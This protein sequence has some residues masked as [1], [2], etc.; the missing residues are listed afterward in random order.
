MEQEKYEKNA[1][2]IIHLVEGMTYT[3]WRRIAHLIG[4]NFDRAQNVVVLKLPPPEHLETQ[5]KQEFIK[6]Y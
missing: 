2:E 4:L 5:M 1:E 6:D 3:Q